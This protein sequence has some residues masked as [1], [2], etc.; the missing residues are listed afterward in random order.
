MTIKNAKSFSWNFKTLTLFQKKNER[1]SFISTTYFLEFYLL[2]V[3]FLP[4]YNWLATGN[5]KQQ[6]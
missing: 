3:G 4:V 1:L 6:Q 5:S 2:P